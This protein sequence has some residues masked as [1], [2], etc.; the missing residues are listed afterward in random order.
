MFRQK[1]RFRSG[2]VFFLDLILSGLAFLLAFKVRDALYSYFP[3]GRIDVFFEAHLELLLIILPLWSV[4]FFFFQLYDTFGRKTLFQELYAIF[5]VVLIG[6]LV[7]GFAVFVLRL[8]MV[9]RVA[10]AL[11]AILDLFFLFGERLVIR[12]IIK[13]RRSKGWGL[14]NILVVGTGKEAEKIA[15][16][17]QQQHHWNL[18]LVGFISVDDARREDKLKGYPVLGGK[19]DFLKIV[20]EN[21]IDEIIFAVP[22]QTMEKLEDLFLLCEEQGIKTRV[23]LTLFPHIFS[24]IFLE[25]LQ[26]I[27]LLTFSTTPTNEIALFWK[28]ALDVALSSIALILLSPLFVVVS[29]LIK[30][31]S[32]GPV[33]FKQ[34]RGGLYFR[35]FVMYKFRSMTADAEKRK[36]K[37]HHLNEADGPIFKIKDDPRI[38]AIGKWIRKTS[39]DELP[40]LINVLKGDMSMVGPRPHPVEEAKKYTTWQRRRLSMKPGITGLWQIGGRSGTTFAES[41][42]LDLDYIDHWSL[43]LDVKILV[44]TIPAVISGR[45][46]S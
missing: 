5:K 11:F 32:E 25:K 34:E 27:P 29:V 24:K 41:M 42:K 19:D 9:S 3:Q 18:R 14:L 4:L 30:K 37:L 31:T 6:I 40:Q 2:V 7:I 36:S 39:I 38:T 12:R 46:A 20:H 22:R 8:F 28:R 33:F 16:V 23:T 17:I 15:E 10:L 44:K 1:E 21:V 45:G 13:Y 26:D 35:R 43:W